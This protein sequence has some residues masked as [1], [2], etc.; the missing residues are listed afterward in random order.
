[1]AFN[2]LVNL[3]TVGED[4]TGS[5]VSISGCTGA[6]CGSGCTSLVTGQ[7]VSSFPKT[8]SGITDTVVSLYV[9]VDNG[10]C[11]GTTQC[12]GI[13]FVT[14]ATAT[15]TATPTNTP[16]PTPTATP[17]PTATATPTPTV[18]PT[19][20]PTNTPTPTPTATSSPCANGVSFEVDSAGQVRYVTCAGITE[21]VTFGIGPQTIS[22]CIENNSLY[23]LGA[24][25]SQV[26]YGSPCV[27][28][29]ATPTAT[30]TP[31]PPVVTFSSTNGTNTSSTPGSTGS[32][33][34]PTITVENSTATIRLR[35]TLQTGYQADS[36]ITISGGGSFYAGPA[37]TI[38]SGG[39]EIVEFNLGVGTYNIV[40][41][42][43]RAISDGTFTVA[44][45]TLSQV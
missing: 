11:S 20:T 17:G 9:K 34:N 7:S 39:S 45:A 38:G 42:V 12:I 19:A 43:V 44:Q 10:Q 8:L 35:V 26:S 32:T 25:I 24:T 18:S 4:I 16:T 27:A 29:T 41:W 3:G 36:T 5:T 28:P 2:A 33:F 30:P 14:G 23:A 22:G 31:L 37:V 15:P 40:N 6:S 21:Y 13:T 1:M